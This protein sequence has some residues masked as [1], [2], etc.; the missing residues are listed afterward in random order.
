MDQSQFL[1]NQALA[2][3]L[4]MLSTNIAS[5][6]R[7]ERTAILREAAD[8]LHADPRHETPAERRAARE[9][10]ILDPK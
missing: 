2:Q 7:D 3:R 10:Y 9:A 4:D 8:R 6:T 1:T 5:F